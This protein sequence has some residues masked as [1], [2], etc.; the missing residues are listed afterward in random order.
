MY[1]L[2]GFKNNKN[3]MSFVLNYIRYTASQRLPEIKLHRKS[4]GIIQVR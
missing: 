2:I 4:H 1:V 3:K